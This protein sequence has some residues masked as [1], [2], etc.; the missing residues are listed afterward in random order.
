MD[1]QLPPLISKALW[2]FHLY[3]NVD[4]PGKIEATSVRGYWRFKRLCHGECLMGHEHPI[5]HTLYFAEH[6]TRDER[7][8]FVS[9]FRAWEEWRSH[10]GTETNL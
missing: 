3:H 6:G 10:Y 8:R 4:D 2:H 5:H 1:T 9:P 7:G